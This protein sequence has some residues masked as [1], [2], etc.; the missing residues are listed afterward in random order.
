[1]PKHV[2]GSNSC[3]FDDAAAAAAVLRFT[4]LTEHASTGKRVASGVEQQA[5][6]CCV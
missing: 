5:K 3:G 2:V 1:M 6:G 4:A